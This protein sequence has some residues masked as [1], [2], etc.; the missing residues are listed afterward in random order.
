M[1]R[2]K[3]DVK[4]CHRGVKEILKMF[5]KE[6]VDSGTGIKLATK[7]KVKTMLLIPFFFSKLIFL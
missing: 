6:G 5:S 1:V 3:T 4:K 2:F 7:E